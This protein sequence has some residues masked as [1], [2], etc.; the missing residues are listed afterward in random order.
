MSIEKVI[1]ISTVYCTAKATRSWL[2][3]THSGFANITRKTCPCLGE[4]HR[5]LWM[6]LSGTCVMSKENADSKCER[7]SPT[8]LPSFPHGFPASAHIPPLQDPSCLTRIAHYGICSPHRYAI[9]HDTPLKP[10]GCET[11]N[12]VI[13][14]LIPDAEF[15]RV[16]TLDRI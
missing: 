13:G 11:R 15:W 9:S 8:Q 12:R 14:I 5:P 3:N 10:I 16:L 2:I 4:I 7:Q 1:P 6:S